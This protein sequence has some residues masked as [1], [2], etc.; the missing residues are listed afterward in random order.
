[1]SVSDLEIDIDCALNNIY[2]KSASAPSSPN[3]R[4]SVLRDIGNVG[5]HAKARRVTFPDDETIVTGY[6]EAPD[7]WGEE[8]FERNVDSQR[9]SGSETLPNMEPTNTPTLNV[10]SECFQPK[11]TIPSCVESFKPQRGEFVG[12]FKGHSTMLLSIALVYCQNS[13]G[14]VFPRA[15]LDSGSQR[16]LIIHEAALAL[17]W[18]CERVNTTICGINGTSQSIKNKVSTV[19]SKNRPFQKLMEFLV[20]PKIMGLT[21]TNKLDISGIKI[22]EYIKLSDENFYLPGRI[23]LLLPNQIFFEIL[24]NGKIKLADGKLILQDTVSGYVASGVMSHN[25][26][27]K[28]YCGLV[29]NANGLN[30]SIKCFGEIE[31]CPDFEIPTMSRE[32]KKN[33]VR[34]TLRV[35]ID[36]TAHF[37]MKMPLSK[38]R[39]CLGDS[40]QMALCRLNSF[41]RRLVQ[42]PKILGLYRNFI[43]EYLEMRHMEE[44]VEDEDSAIVYYLPHHGVYRHKNK[45]TLSFVVFNASS[46]TTSGKSLNS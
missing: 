32:E 34:N 41:C 20:V 40:K 24:N 2:E 23:N 14:E 30:N 42:D 13:R 18:K 33:Y 43:H 7:P 39:S 3:E 29:T 35:L 16:N 38:D 44:V 37:I 19:S 27:N 21:P 9:S 45:T 26:T 46:I 17:G 8:I 22:L 5:C 28:S 25:Y 6:F 15:L 10:N 36:E 1:M 4:S 31:N 12:H 11:Q